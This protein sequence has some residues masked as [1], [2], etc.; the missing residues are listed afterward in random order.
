LK[1]EEKPRRGKIA[2]VE[3]EEALEAFLEAT[4]SS[5]TERL[6]V[7]TPMKTMKSV[8]KKIKSKEMAVGGVLV[9]HPLAFLE[10]EDSSSSSSSVAE[11]EKEAAE[12]GFY[13]G[14]PE[15]DAKE[16]PRRVKIGN[17][18]V[19]FLGVNATKTV[20]WAARRT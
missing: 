4:A 2:R 5:A 9:E 3:S 8:L 17:T 10:E 1:R 18:P 11:A 12:S 19:M 15:S 13:R 7:T 14:V 16:D 20:V 6:V